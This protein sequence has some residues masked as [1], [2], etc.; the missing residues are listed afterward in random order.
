MRYFHNFYGIFKLNNKLAATLG[1]DIGMQQKNKGSS[2]MN[3]WFSPTAIL[4]YTPTA[5]TAIAVRAE[6]YDDPDNVI[7]S[8]NSPNGFSTW[9]FSANFDWRLT[10]NFLWRAEARALVSKD[11]IFIKHD[12]T[13]TD[14]N[15][16][17]TTSLVI[18]F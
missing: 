11:N 15:T 16:T 18:S 10:K 7:V 5:K 9:G 1:F 13:T 8:D 12:G 14:N 2:A 3:V 6:Y 4:R 17:L